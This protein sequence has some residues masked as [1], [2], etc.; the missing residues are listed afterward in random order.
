MI[1]FSIFQ[2]KSQLFLSIIRIMKKHIY[3]FY[4]L[5][6]CLASF[7]AADAPGEIRRDAEGKSPYQYVNPFIGTGG[8][9]HTY[10]GAVVPF[11]MV[12]LSPDTYVADYTKSYNWCAG[13]RYEDPT[14]LGFSHTH[15][16]GTGHSDLGDILIM[17]LTGELKTT[18]GDAAVPGSGY[19]SR[20]SH[21]REKAE[22]GYYSVFLEDS[23]VQAELTATTRAGFHRYTF[24]RSDSAHIIIDLM[25]NIYNYD[26]KV[27]QACFRTHGD[28][29]I[30]G[31]RQTRGWAANRTLY[32]CMEFSKPFSSYGFRKADPSSYGWRATDKFITHVPEIYGKQLL[33]FVN[34]NTTENEPVLVKVGISAV[35]PGGAEANLAGEIPAWDFDRVRAQARDAW[36][37]ELDDIIIS[38]SQKDK[39]IFYT[40]L[41]HTLLAPMTY[42]DIDGRYRG[43]DQ[44]IH[45]A[46][47]FVNSTVYSLWDTYRAAHPLFTILRPEQAGSMIRSMLAHYRQSAWRMLP[48]WSFYNNETWCMIGY[49]AVSVI[50][51]AYVKGI[52]GF[53]PEEAWKAVLD[54]ATRRDYDGLGFYMDLGYVPVDKSD[55]AA[56]KTLEYAYDDWAIA[57]MART[58]GKT[59]EAR[60]F[61][62]RSKN[63]KNVFDPKTSF[64]RAKKSDGSWREPFDPLYSQYGGDYT[65]GNAWQYTWYVP[66]DV[67]G[68]I[69][70]MGGAHQFVKKLDQLFS[71]HTDDEKH[72]LVED[73]SG[74]I[75]QY[76]HGNEPSQHIAYLY[77][78]AGKPWKTQ[79]RIQQVMNNLFD[80]TPAGICGNEDCGQMSAW[81]IFSSLGFY[82]VAPGDG[83]YIIGKPCLP[84]AAVY[85]PGDKQFRMI[86]RDLSDK[87]IY[88]Q[89]ATLNGRPFNRFS[90][91]HSE[92]M[93]GGLL[94]FRMGPKPNKKW[95]LDRGE[96]K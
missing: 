79:E 35:S 44:N 59:E 36:E 17:P 14:I 88:I 74:L 87:N 60:A 49:H 56:S 57:Q 26:G 1:F 67:P 13:Y 66:H 45:Q 95:G 24:P 9:G 7:M 70:L 19:R 11:G 63:Y 71:I 92:I 72:R 4:L 73:I 23:G 32:F 18:P 65:E 48:V 16:S 21:N 33:M 41:Y 8:E 31:F 82:P 51:D 22:P 34:F 39:E 64:M 30:S 5:L 38:G 25:H 43:L 93:A 89:S 62:K 47:G 81:F 29:K 80:N 42:M 40:S 28:R 3:L 84:E 77:N 90:I 91:Q 83:A 96:Q 61:M 78:F 12:Q 15:F 69:A 58:M 6:W 37:K 27:L 54:T 2:L 76:A 46:E 85:L 68:L 94:E 75:G 52:G 86:A 20:F 53:D 50:A 10:P 55:E